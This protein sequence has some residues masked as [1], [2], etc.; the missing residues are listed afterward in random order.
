MLAG[1]FP[2]ALCSQ[3]VA[4]VA[5]TRDASSD[6]SRRRAI[7]LWLLH[8]NPAVAVDS[9]YVVWMVTSLF[10]W[11][12]AWGSDGL[13]MRHRGAGINVAMRGMQR[14]KMRVGGILVERLGEHHLVQRYLREARSHRCERGG[15]QELGR[16]VYDGCYVSR[17]G[18]EAR[19]KLGRRLEIK[20]F[21]LS[22]P[23]TKSW[24]I[25]VNSKS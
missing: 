14:W 12:V 20:T 3:L 10:R 18:A 13:L 6:R 21:F 5:G 7:H 19:E 24:G 4:L 15:Y 17:T 8:V 22:D 23:A 1:Q 2:V 9:V 16:K 11:F 25:P